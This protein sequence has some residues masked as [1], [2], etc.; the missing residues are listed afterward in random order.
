ML[1]IHKFTNEL[2]RMESNNNYRA[3]N[4]SGALG[5]YQF[6]PPTL[7]SLQRIY[8][9][10]EWVDANYFLNSPN[11]QDQYFSAHLGD[12][13]SFI[14]N[15]NLK[16]YLNQP[17]KGSMRFKNLTVPLTEAG[18]IASMHLAGTGNVKKFLLYGDDPNDGLTALSD[19]A[20]YFSNKFPDNQL[21]AQFAG[22]S[23]DNSLISGVAFMLAIVLYY[24]QQK[25]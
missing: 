22:I 20:A 25:N 14:D 18:L 19:Y 4:K 1:S 2:G 8:N 3:R 21:K 24:I 17:V 9:L 11:L 7:N 23:I 10:P 5:R 15:N 6:M 13:Q 16:V 12:L